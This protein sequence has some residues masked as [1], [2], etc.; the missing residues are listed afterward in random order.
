MPAARYQ[1]DQEV[2]S[3]EGHKQSDSAAH[4]RQQNA[5]RQQLLHDSSAPCAHRHSHGDFSLSRCGARKLQIGNVRTGDQQDESHKGHQN[6]QR[7]REFSAQVV[8]PFAAGL[9]FHVRNGFRFR[10]RLDVRSQALLENRIELSARRGLGDARLQS[11][12]H[13]HP[14][15]VSRG[16]ERGNW[17]AARQGALGR[18]RGRPARLNLW[19]EMQGQPDLDR[20]SRLHAEEFRRADPDDG[21]GNTID[22]QLFADGRRVAAEAP[23]P[24]TVADYG[25]GLRPNA[26]IF[27]T[28]RAAEN[29]LNAERS[30]KASGNQLPL[31]AARFS[32]VAD[33]QLAVAPGQRQ[34]V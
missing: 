33:V 30:E 34:N 10:G 19:L 7:G 21:H 3:P 12:Y 25:R 11:A 15:V 20:T 8:Q 5:F 1:S 16:K 27:R 17:L 32:D 31:G 24:I 28:E 4:E 14:P 6:K 9:E 13:D 2:R 23:L 22:R 29:R 26:I 18:A